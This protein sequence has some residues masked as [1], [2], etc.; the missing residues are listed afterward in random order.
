MYHIP[1]YAFRA[2]IIRISGCDPRYKELALMKKEY[3]LTIEIDEE[4][5]TDIDIPY[6]SGPYHSW[7]KNQIV[8]ALRDVRCAPE[9]I[10]ISPLEPYELAALQF[11]RAIAELP[12]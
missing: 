5:F 4:L 11:A 9:H 2:A 3:K 6:Y 1:N 8:M 12:K 7:L 10:Q